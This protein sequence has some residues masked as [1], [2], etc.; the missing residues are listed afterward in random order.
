MRMAPWN[1]KIALATWV[2]VLGP[3]MAVL[4][5]RGRSTSD[6]ETAAGLPSDILDQAHVF[7]GA[8]AT[9]RI[10]ARGNT[11]KYIVTKSH[12]AARFEALSFDG[13]AAALCSACVA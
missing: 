7:S 6:Y 10:V 11:T 4:L 1:R 8:T 13:C 9:D 3:L 5:G 12:G 2:M